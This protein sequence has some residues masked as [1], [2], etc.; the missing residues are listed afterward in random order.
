MHSDAR[1][2]A[3]SRPPRIELGIGMPRPTR[4]RPSGQVRKRSIDAR[5]VKPLHRQSCNKYRSE[6]TDEFSAHALFVEKRD[7]YFGRDRPV[8]IRSMDEPV[9]H[10][11]VSET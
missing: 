5:P 3:P 9:S 10:L 2:S 4:S 1:Q 6:Q 11:P 7:G 8:I